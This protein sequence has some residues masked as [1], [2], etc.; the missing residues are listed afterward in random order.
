MKR[1]KFNIQIAGKEIIVEK[2]EMAE[3]ANG[4]VLVR[5]GDSVVL[6]TAVMGRHPSGL[7]YFPL[8]VEYQEKFYASGKIPGSFLKRESRPSDTAILKS[9]LIDRALRPL[10]N[11][12]IENNIQVVATVLSADLENDTD[13]IAMN[14]ASTALMISDIPFSGPVAAVRVGKIDG[15]FVINPTFEERERS[16]LDMVV[17]GTLD[18][19]NMIEAGANEIPEK[20]ILEAIDFARKEIVKLA[21]FQLE[22]QQKIGKEKQKL[23]IPEPSQELIDFVLSRSSEKINEILFGDGNKQEKMNELYDFKNEVLKSIE[24]NYPENPEYVSLADKIFEKEIDRITHENAI[25]H[26]KRA[27]GRKL[28]ELREIKVQAGIVPR[29]HGS[30]FFKRGQTQALSLLTLGS[31]AESQ[32][33]D[34]MDQD[35]KK[36]FMHHYNFPPFS[37]GEAAPLRGPSRRDIG[38]GHLAER[39]IVPILP[40]HD[41]FPYTIRIV[42]EI[43]SSNGSSSMASV[44]GSSI[45]L[46]DGGVPIKK[47]AAGIAMGLMT[48]YENKDNYVVLTDIQGPEDHHG[49]MD[50]KAA[51]TK[52]GITALQMDVKIEGVTLKMLQDTLR[53]AKKARYEIIEKIEKVIPKPRAHISKYAPY[54]EKIQIDP[55]KIGLVIGTG[56]KTINH[57]IAESGAEIAIEEDGTVFVSGKDKEVVKHAVK[58]IRALTVEPKVGDVFEGRVTKVTDFG[59]F[60]EFLPGKEGLVHISNLKNERVNSVSDVVSEGDIVKVKIINIDELGRYQLSM[61]AVGQK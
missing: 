58:M 30:G 1:A 37:V 8:N 13:I 32:I 42:S 35:T 31:P 7:N 39:A 50:F 61:K 33:L 60:V 48:D 34:T 22:I 28:D 10:F 36:Y 9:R 17:A 25:K 53:Q 20:E 46:M 16:E 59:A 29:A 6:C 45:A 15:R 57:I 55:T 52:D 12:D 44:C 40:S 4:S 2:N 18:R 26:K 3:Q 5:M 27:D 24:E 47:I 21:N 49:D 19:I 23:D 38:H 43:L 11:H 51:G 41:D 56:G 54:I 14:A